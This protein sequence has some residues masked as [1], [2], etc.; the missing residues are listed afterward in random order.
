MNKL[1]LITAIAKIEGVKTHE[2][3]GALYAAENF[4]EVVNTYKDSHLTNGQ[5]LKIIKRLQYDPLTDKAMLRDL[6]IKHRDVI[7]RSSVISKDDVPSPRLFLEC[8]VEANNG[9]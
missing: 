4:N 3:N 1:E 6:M 5:A 2:F 7:A 8:I 9:N